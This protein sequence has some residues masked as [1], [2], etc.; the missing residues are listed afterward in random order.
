[1]TADELAVK[2]D[3]AIRHINDRIEL[4]RNSLTRLPS[5]QQLALDK[6]ATSIHP[7]AV[8][9]RQIV[10]LAVAETLADPNTSRVSRR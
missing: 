2:I 1:M 4:N 9:L 10:R 7:C 6:Y 5:V 8:A 3:H